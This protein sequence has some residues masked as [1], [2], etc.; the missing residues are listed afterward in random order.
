MKLYSVE[1][2]S[3]DEYK[4]SAPSS[5]ETLGIRHLFK[6]AYELMLSDYQKELDKRQL[7]DNDAVNVATGEN[8]PGGAL[9]E[10][11]AYILDTWKWQSTIAEPHIAVLYKINPVIV[12]VPGMEDINTSRAG[13]YLVLPTG[14]LGTLEP[15]GKVYVIDD[16]RDT[17][18]AGRIYRQ[19]QKCLLWG[20]IISVKYEAPNNFLVEVSLAQGIGDM[21]DER[22]YSYIDTFKYGETAFLDKALAEQA[23]HAQA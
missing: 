3:V 11:Y 14:E 18:A 12:E 6:D 19:K 22:L 23:F 20:D 2:V 8:I 7:E 9:F 13:N 4:F 1:K 21:F 16:S 10:T 15:G 5:I 17:N